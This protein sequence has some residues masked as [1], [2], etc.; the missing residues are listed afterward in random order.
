M[1]AIGSHVRRASFNLDAVKAKIEAAGGDRQVNQ[2]GIADHDRATPDAAR[3]TALALAPQH[4]SGDKAPFASLLKGDVRRRWP[5]ANAPYSKSSWPPRRMS[6]EGSEDRAGRIATAKHPVTKRHY[7]EWS[8]VMLEV[9]TS[10]RQRLQ[11]LHRVSGGGI[12][13]MRP[14]TNRCMASRPSRSSAQQQDAVP[15]ARRQA[16]THAPAGGE[17]H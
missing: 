7:T 8:I 14:W 1:T 9:L 5:A 16:G 12:E 4:P 10:A 11:D 13:F 6:T 15:V 2:R 17:L 3:S